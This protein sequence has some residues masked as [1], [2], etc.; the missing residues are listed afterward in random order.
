MLDG[1]LLESTVDAEQADA[2]LGQ[3][4]LRDTFPYREPLLEPGPLAIHP[5]YDP[6]L[7]DERLTV[8]RKNIIHIKS[9]SLIPIEPDSGP[10]IGTRV[11]VALAGLVVKVVMALGER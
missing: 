5:L 10:L 6:S 3:L 11:L 9:A 1:G 8:L 4:L 2:S 7:C